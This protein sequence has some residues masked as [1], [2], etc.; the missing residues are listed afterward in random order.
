MNI[1]KDIIDARKSLIHARDQLDLK[2]RELQAEI[3]AR[4]E[5]R[6]S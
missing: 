3:A 2:V 1:Q 6:E 5:Q 4:N